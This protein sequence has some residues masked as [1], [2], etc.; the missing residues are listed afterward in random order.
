MSASLAKRTQDL[1]AF[2]TPLIYERRIL[3]ANKKITVDPK[4]RK[5]MIH[6]TV[7]S[8]LFLAPFLLFFIMFVVYPM[9]MCVFTSFFD[10]TMGREDI[11]VGFGNYK[12]LFQD[13][14]FWIA[15]K[16]TLVIVLVS[17]P[18]TCIFSLWVASAISKMPVA[19]TSAFRCIFYLPVVTGSVAVTM[20]WKWMF[21]NY[22]GIFNYLGTNLGLID[23]N[24]NWLGDPK[25]ALGCI[26]LILLTTS[27]GQPIV[28]YV[29]ALDNV[30][31]SLVEAAEVDGATQM[32]AFWRIK[33][34]QMMPTTLYILV[35]TTINSFQCFALIQLLTLGGPSNSTMTI[36]YYIYYNAFKL[37]KYGYGNAM[38]VILAIII[39]I[40]SAVQFKLGE[41]K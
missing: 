27:V 18:V 13:D 22:Y 7:T 2:S 33:W 31:K 14:V 11:F 20:V 37:Y 24:I 17:V 39:A 10:A 16:N 5:L 36:M 28:L 35:I 38:G 30:D 6:E 29:S 40:L 8:Y 26:I 4:S 34:P 32:Q 3:L 41:E 25:Y 1:F 21:N 12:T 9:F 15:L 23:K 19:A